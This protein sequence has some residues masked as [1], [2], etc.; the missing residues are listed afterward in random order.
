MKEIDYQGN[1][2]INYTEFLA[3]TISVKKF[4]T[5]EKMLA[6]FKQFDT[7]NSGKIT[8]DNI[9]G[10]MHKMNHEVTENDIKEIMDKH[11]L[12]NNKHLD[13]NDFKTIFKEIN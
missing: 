10:A 11:N 9:I 3:A 1:K 12:K 8:I 13:Y 5:E 2:K 4:L 6:L 7:D